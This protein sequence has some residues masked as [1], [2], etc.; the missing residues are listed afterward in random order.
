[1]RSFPRSVLSPC[2]RPGLCPRNIRDGLQ[3]VENIVRREKISGAYG[4]L[5]N[6]FTLVDQVRV[7]V[8]VIAKNQLF[9]YVVDTEATAA[10]LIAKLQKVRAHRATASR[11]GERERRDSVL[12]SPA[13]K[14]ALL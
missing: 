7:P 3:T 11:V 10:K 14:L 5:V 6:L 13:T 8:E 4:P 1:M 12:R 2:G 9:N